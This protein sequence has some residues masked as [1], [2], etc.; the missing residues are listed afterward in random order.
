MDFN[1]GVDNYPYNQSE[2]HDIRVE[3]V[4]IVSMR[5]CSSTDNGSGLLHA[6]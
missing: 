2:L 1:F 3:N 6:N 5:S 4:S